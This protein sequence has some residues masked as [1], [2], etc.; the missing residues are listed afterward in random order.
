MK[1]KGIP[2]DPKVFT[3]RIHAARRGCGGCGTK[4]SMPPAGDPFSAGTH[5][6]RYW[7]PDCW[8]L[9]YDE[10]PEH[11]ADQETRLFVSKEALKIRQARGK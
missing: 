7:C 2:V 3:R 5:K 4:I 11:L 1:E 9:Y 8:T 10:H 6:D